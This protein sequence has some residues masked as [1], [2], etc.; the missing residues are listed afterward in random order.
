MLGFGATFK[1]TS[2]TTGG[3]GA[4]VGTC[5]RVRRAP[6]RRRLPAP[7]KPRAPVSEKVNNAPFQSG[8][9]EETVM[10]DNDTATSLVFAPEDIVWHK[11]DL[12]PKFWLSDELVD[13]DYSSVFSAQ[14]T[15]FGPGGGSSPHSYTY[16]HAFYF[17]SGTCSVQIEEQ[18]WHVKPGTF[19]T[20][21]PHISSTASS[22]TAPKTS[23]SSSSTTR[24]TSTARR[25][26]PEKFRRID[27]LGFRPWRLRAFVS[28]AGAAPEGYRKQLGRGLNPRPILSPATSPRRSPKPRRWRWARHRSP[29][30]GRSRATMARGRVL[31]GQITPLLLGSTPGHPKGFC[32]SSSAAK[33]YELDG[34][35]FV[36]KQLVSRVMERHGQEVLHPGR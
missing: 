24:P 28:A 3:F 18:N 29:A 16:N 35:S 10:S 1:L 13:P 4:V 23:S 36:E 26:S 25:R 30:N 19:V 34:L 8:A 11:T 12:G 21:S 9:G 5:S 2:R 31:A 6:W 27:R 22:T 32:R 20:R 33:N 17:L 14:L 7:M 15:K